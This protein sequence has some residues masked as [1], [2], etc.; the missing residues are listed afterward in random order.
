MAHE[1]TPVIHAVAPDLRRH[2][3][4]AIVLPVRGPSHRQ[5]CAVEACL[6]G[7]PVVRVGILA[8]LSRKTIV[9]L[10]LGDFRTGVHQTCLPAR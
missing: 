6:C 9:R 7:T 5:I 4:V 10:I 8:K 2:F 3:G 1:L